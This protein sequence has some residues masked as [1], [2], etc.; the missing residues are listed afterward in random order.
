MELRTL[1][2]TA[3]FA[4]SLARALKP[5]KSYGFIGELGAGKTTL[6]SALCRELGVT[7]PVS[8]PS[9]VLE[10]QYAGANVRFEHWDLYRLRD[11]PLDLYE[12]PEPDTIRLV[13]WADRDTEFAARLDGVISID[14]GYGDDGAA[15]RKVTLSGELSA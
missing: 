15:L 12:P 1:E 3:R 11:L 9:F 14:L 8:S 2:D 6:I 5:G 4:G 10:H 13:E 7:E